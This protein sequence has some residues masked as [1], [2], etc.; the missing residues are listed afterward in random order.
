MTIGD[1]IRI[2][3]TELGLTQS[4]LA[5]RLGYTSRTSVCTIEK[6][7]EDLTTTR[8]KKFADALETT[9]AY[10]MGWEEESNKPVSFSLDISSEVLEQE[11]N[12]KYEKNKSKISVPNF[13][14]QNNSNSIDLNMTCALLQARPELAE[15]LIV[16]KD[17]SKENVEI[18]VS[19]LKRMK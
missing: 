1:R 10:L 19:M 17:T 5:H 15:L 18:A 4:E 8:V 14:S 13:K 11:C 9:P 12:D 16:A 6:N 7:K 2:R 3:R